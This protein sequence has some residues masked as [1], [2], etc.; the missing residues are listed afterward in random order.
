M[1]TGHSGP[2]LG[3]YLFSIAVIADTHMNE[4]EYGS[5]SPYECNQVAN[6]RTRWVIHRINQLRPELTIHLGDLVHPVP[7]Q[8][9]FAQAAGNFKQLTS[10]LEAPLYLAPGNHD[11][12]FEVDGSYALARSSRWVGASSVAGSPATRV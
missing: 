10:A 3:R 4:E 5:A 7:A 9:T 8:P 2:D 6:S 12:R 1:T 11:Y